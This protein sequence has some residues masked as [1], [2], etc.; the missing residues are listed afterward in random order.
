MAGKKSGC[1]CFG[2]GCLTLFVVAG[3]VV[4]FL[5]FAGYQVYLA[6]LE[7]TEEGPRSLPVVE[8]DPGR[9][10]EVMGRMEAFTAA[11]EGAELRL[12]GEDLN[13]YVQ[14]VPAWESARGK[15]YFAIEN[16]IAY[17]EASFPLTR[18]PALAQR[19]VNGRVGLALA[20]EAGTPRVT[21]ESLTVGGRPAPTAFMDVVVGKDFGPTLLANPQVAEM[22]KGVKSLSVEGSELILRK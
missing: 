17:S 13:Q 1:G 22:F 4:G 2:F 6:A 8:L 19:W 7:F 18:V 9:L 5:G 20:V 11:K 3:M 10:A 12:S 14:G 21:I 15:V 16:G